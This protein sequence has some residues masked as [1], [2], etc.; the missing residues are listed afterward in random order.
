[1]GSG[2]DRALGLASISVGL[3]ATVVLAIAV[4]ADYWLYTDEPVD[5]GMPPQPTPTAQGGHDDDADPVA[6]SSVVAMVTTH[7]GLW[8][9]CVDSK[10]DYTG[11]KLFSD[12]AKFS[13]ILI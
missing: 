3:L 9:I 12:T 10:F 8:R 7:S 4:S 1:M 5:T 6:P 2:M 11:M 13:Y